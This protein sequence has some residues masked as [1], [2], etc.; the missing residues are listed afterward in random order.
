MGTQAVLFEEVTGNKWFPSTVTITWCF[1]QL[2]PHSV[3]PSKQLLF[4]S[5]LR[6]LNQKPSKSP[7]SLIL[8]IFWS[9]SANNLKAKLCKK[10]TTTYQ[11][12]YKKLPYTKLS[13]FYCHKRLLSGER[14]CK[15]TPT[16]YYWKMLALR[17]RPMSRP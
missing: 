17:K 13:T 4:P 15:Q 12:P 6:L 9:L 8:T 14:E 16:S 10:K 2:F 11:I 3:R 1:H 5:F 7:L